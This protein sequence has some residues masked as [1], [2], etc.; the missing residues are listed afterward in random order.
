MCTRN[1]RRTAL[2]IAGSYDVCCS[3]RPITFVISKSCSTIYL[4]APLFCR[5]LDAVAQDGG[6]M[7]VRPLFGFLPLV[8]LDVRQRRQSPCVSHGSSCACLPS[9]PLIIGSSPSFSWTFSR[10]LVRGEG[11]CACVEEKKNGSRT[12]SSSEDIEQH[13][14]VAIKVVQDS[15]PPHLSPAL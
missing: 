7:T 2:K 3:S 13:N 15:P 11:G 6:E 8:Y 12:P 5:P 14:V 4:V 9:V 1:S 10:L